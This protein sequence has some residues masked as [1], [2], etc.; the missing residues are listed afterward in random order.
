MIFTFRIGCGLSIE[1]SNQ[2]KLIQ[3]IL[4]SYDRKTKPTWDNNKA[5]NVTFSMDL[6]QIL[7]LNEPQQFLLLNS[8]IIERWHDEFLFWHPEEYGNITELRL[9]YDCIWLPDTTLYNSLVMK[10]DDSRRLLNAKLTTNITRK[11]VLVE[12]LYPTIYKFSCL[13][14]L[15]Y[16]PYDLQECTMTFSSWTYDSKGIDYLPYADNIGTSNYLENEGWYLLKTTIQR[17]EVKYSCCPNN[18]TLLKLKLYLRRK[19]LFYLINLIIPT[20]IIT[21]IAIVGFFTTSSASGMREEKV[22][23]GITTLLSMSILML[24]VSDQMPT[25]ST[26]IPLIGWFILGMIGVISMGTLASSFVIGVQK[27]GRL[28]ERLT[29]RSV[30]IAKIFGII[31]FTEV[32]LHLRKGTQEYANAPPPSDAYRKSVKLV[33]NLA[34]RTDVDSSP[35][36]PTLFQHPFKKEENKKRSVFQ[37]IFN[38]KKG[39]K[40]N[41]GILGE[42]GEGE[43]LNNNNNNKIPTDK[44]TEPLV[45]AEIVNQH[46]RIRR[47]TVDEGSQTISRHSSKQLRKGQHPPPLA[48]FSLSLIDQ[49]DEIDSQGSELVTPIVPNRSAAAQMEVRQAVGLFNENLRLSRQ[50]A[51]KE[52]EWLATILERCCFIV[53]VSIFLCLSLGINYIGFLHWGNPNSAFDNYS[54]D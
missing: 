24:M 44:S 5:I 2:M 39:I 28:G 27:R 43:E 41:G 11:A 40:S 42:G 22:S 17:K 34:G 3:D 31:S 6:Y 26:F 25:T 15:R 32:P 33:R 16:F 23:L 8:W 13:L 52:Y 47:N 29:R 9:P 51:Q 50:L 53:F 37:Q 38:N 49:N 45:A 1:A 36:N 46:Q 30:K 54:E 19:P 10:D 4:E 35:F 20:A 12:L 7:E 21:L 48:P 14:N 18:Y